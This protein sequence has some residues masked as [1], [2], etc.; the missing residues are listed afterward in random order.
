[1]ALYRP[2]PRDFIEEFTLRKNGK[3]KVE[4]L[5]DSLI[6][7]LKPTYGII[8]YQEQILQIATKFAGFS[9]SKADILRRAMSKKEE[10]KM[11]A[12]KEEFINGSIEKGHSKQKAEE[13]FEL[14]LK[15][16]SYGFNK[17]HTVV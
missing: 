4:Y 10:N 9:L 6:D 7:I 15:F 16:A 1:M 12:L 8:V 3:V 5:D 13:V 11:I 2:G 17:A 14:V